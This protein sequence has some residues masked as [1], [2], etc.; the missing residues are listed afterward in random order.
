[1]TRHVFAGFGFGPIQAGLFVCEAFASGEFLSD[2]HRRNRP[3]APS[4]ARDAFIDEFGAALISK[5]A[6]L[7][8][9]LFTPA[10][11]AEYADDLLV[12]MTNPFL[13]DTTARAGRDPVRKLGL[14]DRIFGTISLAHSQNVTPKKV[15]L[16]AVAG[17][18]VLLA[19]V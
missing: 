17:L 9:E 3:L 16:A 8:D 11:F 6:H 7:G 5:H 12:R 14:H 13:T 15:A 18:A 19:N 2:R 4:A 1:M 10:G